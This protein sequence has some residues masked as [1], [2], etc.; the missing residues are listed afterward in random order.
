MPLTTIA[1]EKAG[2]ALARN[3]VALGVAAGLTGVGLGPIESV[4]RQNFA[5]K[6]DSVVDANLAPFERGTPRA[7]SE[8]RLRLRSP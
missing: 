5:R 6:G 7:D 2:S 1:K 3:T 8:R 4:I